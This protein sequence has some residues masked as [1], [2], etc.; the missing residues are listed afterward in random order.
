MMSHLIYPLVNAF[1]GMAAVFIL[2]TLLFIAAFALNRIF[3]LVDSEENKEKT[4]PLKLH[5]TPQADEE[6]V[7]VIQAAI[8][9]HLRRVS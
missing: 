7:A 6:T 2:F 5:I 9:A 1:T 8:S 3:P 4:E